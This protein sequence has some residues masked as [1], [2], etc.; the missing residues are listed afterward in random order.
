MKLSTYHSHTTFSDGKS[1][2][3]EMILAAIER[4]CPEIGISEHS[5]IGNAKWSM[6]SLNIESYIY[7]LKQLREKYK[8]KIK[9]YIG[10]EQ[11]IIS[12]NTTECFDYVIGSVHSVFASGREWDVDCSSEATREAIEKG[13]GGDPYSYCEAYYDR[14]G[15]LYEK[16]GCDIIGHFDLVTKFIE[17]DPVFS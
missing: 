2:A 17:S 15:K 13:F 3:E 14:V 16:T 6:S 9:I 1:T 11:D 5:P 12:I 7:T 8:N 4:G 10:I